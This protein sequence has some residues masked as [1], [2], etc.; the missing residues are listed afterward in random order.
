MKSLMKC[1]RAMYKRKRIE[2]F[3]QKERKQKGR[4]KILSLRKRK[5]IA[6]AKSKLLKKEKVIQ[7]PIKISLD[8]KTG[9]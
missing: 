2:K 9:T 7:I 5:E 3:Q 4:T 8:N 6:N 1:P